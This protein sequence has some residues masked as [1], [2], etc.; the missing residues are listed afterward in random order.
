MLPW[1]FDW[2]M[3]EAE[4]AKEF[5]NMVIIIKP[6]AM[7]YDKSIPLIFSTDL[8]SAKLKTARNKSELIAGPII[9]WIPTFKKRKISF[10]INVRKHI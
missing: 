2:P 7:K 9:V 3:L 1:N 5:C 10:L 4:L 6:G 8:P